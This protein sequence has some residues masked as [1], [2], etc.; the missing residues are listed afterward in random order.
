ML[1]ALRIEVKRHVYPLNGGADYPPRSL[2]T[3]AFPL[4]QFRVARAGVAPGENSV[5]K[6]IPR[7]SFL[8]FLLAILRV[9]RERRRI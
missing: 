2:Y 8:V 5:F 4:A 1:L 3:R 6:W 9:E 7:Q